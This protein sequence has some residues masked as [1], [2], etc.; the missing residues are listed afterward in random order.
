[1]TIDEVQRD[2]D[3]WFERYKIYKEHIGVS[4]ASEEHP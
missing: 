1:M 3:A 4:G 2:L